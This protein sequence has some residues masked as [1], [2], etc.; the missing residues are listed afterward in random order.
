M[1]R[2]G[3]AFLFINPDIINQCFIVGE[4]LNDPSEGGRVRHHS[5]FTGRSPRM[6]ASEIIIK[7]IIAGLLLLLLLHSTI[8]GDLL[9]V[10]H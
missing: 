1:R 2:R 8:A 9:L 3:R 5:V 6:L 7:T 4:G 10:K